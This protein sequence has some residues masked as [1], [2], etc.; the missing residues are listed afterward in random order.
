M[1]LSTFE[2][3]IKAAKKAQDREA[4]MGEL[5]ARIKTLEQENALLKQQL[6]ELKSQVDS[7]KP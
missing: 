6:N 4:T 1:K 2:R 5:R 7:S 3:S